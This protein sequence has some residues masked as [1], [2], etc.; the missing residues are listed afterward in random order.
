MSPRIVAE[1][2]EWASL[3]DSRSADADELMAYGKWRDADPRHRETIDRML[4]FDPLGQVT[5]FER[6]ALDH[7]M[8]SRAKTAAGMRRGGAALSVLLIAAGGWLAL[9][10]DAVQDR[11][12]TYQTPVGSVQQADLADGSILSIDTG[13]AVRTAMAPDVRRVRL[14]R[15]RLLAEVSRNPARPFVVETAEGTATALGTAFTVSR[16][17]R[18]TLV[19]VASSHVRVCAQMTV[20][21]RILGPGQRA[22][23]AGGQVAMLTTE[24]VARIGQWA[25]GWLEADDQDLVQVV[26]QLNHYRSDP[27]RYDPVTLAGI[28]VTGSYPLTDPSRALQALGKTPGAALVKRSDGAWHIVRDTAAGQP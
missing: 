26:E 15:G 5:G 27:V 3:I 12:P 16:D 22:R 28:R 20:T 6:R 24:P 11:F 17:G 8:R 9:R 2:A 13:S 10:S 7:A 4:S 1:A 14:I 25:S 18:S 23:I 19:E 21:C